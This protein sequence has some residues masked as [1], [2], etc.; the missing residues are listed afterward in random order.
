MSPSP[1]TDRNASSSV[2]HL[3]A[4][5]PSRSIRGGLVAPRVGIFAMNR[6]SLA[7]ADADVGTPMRGARHV[8]VPT[9]AKLERGEVTGPFPGR[10]APVTNEPTRSNPI[11]A[12]KRRD[13][14]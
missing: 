6:R 10:D 3:P 14:G 1:L 9:V 11:T 7:S 4:T 12:V 5:S 13:Q 2:L 8:R